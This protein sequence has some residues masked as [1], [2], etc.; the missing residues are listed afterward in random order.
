MAASPWRGAVSLTV[1]V[2]IWPFNG[3]AHPPGQEVHG[4]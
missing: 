2:R 4:R 3:P 1:I